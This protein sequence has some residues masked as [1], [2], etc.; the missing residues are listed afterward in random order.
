MK[1]IY[2]WLLFATLVLGLLFSRGKEA[3]AAQAENISVTVPGNFHILFQSDGTNQTNPFQINNESPVPIQV[4]NMKITEY[5]EWQLVSEEIPIEADQKK[6]TFLLEGQC[7]KAGDNSLSIPVPEHTKKNLG[8]EIRRGAWN[9]NAVSEKALSLEIEYT[10][11]TK[12]FD[13]TFDSNGSKEQYE[14]ISVANGSNVKLPAPFLVKHNFLGWEDEN[15]VL[16]N[17]DFVMPTRNVVLTAKW[18]RTEAYA[19]YCAEDQSL[20]FIRSVEPLQPGDAYL[21]KI[22]TEVYTGIEDNVYNSNAMQ[23]WYKAGGIWGSDIVKVD[24]LDVIQPI[25]TAY[26][27]YN[28]R[29]V[30][31]MNLGKLDLSKVTDM[32]SMF[33]STGMDVT[34]TFTIRG[35]GQWDTSNVRCMMTVFRGMGKSAKQFV[36][37]DISGWDTS[38][39]ED[40]LY[41]FFQTGESATWHMDLS[42]WNIKKVKTHTGFCND[43]GTKIIQPK[44]VN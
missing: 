34:D 19:I 27:F 32:T 3:N 40:M 26:W 20:L 17:G 24:A 41:M 42:S 18:Q 35:I 36:M 11:E 4:K 14:T 22:I 15:G 9:Q 39:A 37:E 8:I 29:D 13:I 38:S 28:M 30:K 7:L 5:N 2:Q 16:Y 43:N 6:L 1:R 10:I 25:S 44:W 33:S 31:E 23:P 21:G 12:E